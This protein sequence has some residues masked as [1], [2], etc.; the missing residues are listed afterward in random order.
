LASGIDSRIVPPWAKVPTSMFLHGG[1]LHLIGNM[2]VLWVFGNSMEEALG[3]GRYLFLNHY[4]GI[5]AALTQAFSAPVSHV[6]M[7]GASGAIAGSIG[8]YLLLFPRANI[9]CFIWIVFFFR[10]INIPAWILLGVWFAAQAAQIVSRLTQA[11]GRS[12]VAFWG[13][14]AGS[15]L[16][17]SR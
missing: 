13:I 12:G 6:P 7:L 3:A 11:L 4:C 17:R 15:A 5:A 14:S 10:I 16:E 2:V 1:W 8:A 9:R